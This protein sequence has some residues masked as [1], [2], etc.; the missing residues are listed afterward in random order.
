MDYGKKIEY[1]RVYDHRTG[2]WCYCDQFINTGSISCGICQYISLFGREE[3]VKAVAAGFLANNRLHI[4]HG[5]ED[6]QR[7]AGNYRVYTR[8]T[9][10]ALHKIVSNVTMFG[11]KQHN[12]IILGEGL[13]E[14]QDE[15]FK[16]MDRTLTTPL[17]PKW[18]SRLFEWMFN[19][20]EGAVYARVF[21]FDGKEALEVNIPEEAVVEEFILKYLL[22]EAA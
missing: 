9:E 20:A 12:Q 14:L 16:A 1:T 7:D 13:C 10:N 11:T 8:K 21:G 17:S 15:L 5:N 4:E 2:A 6:V 3:S 19:N 22:D 18:M